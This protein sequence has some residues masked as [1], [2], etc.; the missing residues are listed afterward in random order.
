MYNDI[1]QWITKTISCY[2]NPDFTSLIIVFKYTTIKLSVPYY[3]KFHYITQCYS[4][5]HFI[6]LK[7]S[8]LYKT[9]PFHTTLFSIVAP[10]C[11]YLDCNTI[12]VKNMSNNKLGNLF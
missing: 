10:F 4:N 3:I 1:M 5:F 8:T 9:I 12:M 2:I 6:I 11:I 7:S